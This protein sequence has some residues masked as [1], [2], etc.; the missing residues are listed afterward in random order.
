MRIQFAAF[1]LGSTVTLG[2]AMFSS[3]TSAQTAPAA[4]NTAAPAAPAL[5][6]GGNTADGDTATAA[7]GQARQNFGITNYTHHIITTLN[8]S[9][10]GE[11][12]WGPNILG[13]DTLGNG[14]SAEITFARGETQC[15]WDIRAT[16]DDGGTTYMRDVDLCIVASVALTAS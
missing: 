8:V 4:L 14:E 16:Y 13:G 1:L 7:G 3:A 5:P 9:P 10:T 2:P 11:D 6:A 12:S 15:A